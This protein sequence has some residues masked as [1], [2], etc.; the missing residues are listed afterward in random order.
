MGRTDQVE[1]IYVLGHQG[2]MRGMTPLATA[3]AMLATLGLDR[4]SA[5]QVRRRGLGGILRVLGQLRLELDDLGAGRC[6]LGAGRCQLS[7]R[8]RKLGLQRGH[9][10]KQLLICR[11]GRDLMSK[12]RLERMSSGPVND[13][14]RATATMDP[15]RCVGGASESRW[16]GRKLKSEIIVMMTECIHNI[17]HLV[18]EV[19]ATKCVVNTYGPRTV[20]DLG[21]SE[22]RRRSRIGS[23]RTRRQWFVA[24]LERIFMTEGV[25]R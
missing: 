13:Y 9:Q 5:G 14:K 19:H 15:S 12:V 24:E 6:Q 18:N 17:G 1:L 21:T 2:L 3:L 25:S 10:C 4:A 11:L 20:G 8:D 7:A 16:A 22:K 23:E